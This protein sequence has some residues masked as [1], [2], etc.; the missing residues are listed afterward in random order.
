MLYKCILLLSLILLLLLL[1]LLLYFLQWTEI[2][3]ILRCESFVYIFLSAV[4]PFGRLDSSPSTSSDCSKASVSSLTNGNS[5]DKS[6]SDEKIKVNGGLVT[7]A[8]SPPDVKENSVKPEA[9][10]DPAKVPKCLI[11]E[12]GIETTAE[13]KNA[14]I[15]SSPEAISSCGENELMII[16]QSPPTKVNR[17]SKVRSLIRF[18]Y[19]KYITTQCHHVALNYCI[20]QGL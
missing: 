17:K 2:H 19:Y 15:T 20:F 8:P 18:C 9:S 12:N 10:Y 14:S 11:L 5:E 7:G 6:H 1:S 13:E 16:D 3:Y 4:L